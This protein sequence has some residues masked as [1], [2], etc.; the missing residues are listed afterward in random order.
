MDF[1]TDLKFCCKKII[2]K[3]IQDSNGPWKESTNSYGWVWDHFFKQEV[4]SI[5]GNF[6]TFIPIPLLVN[7]IP[8]FLCTRNSKKNINRI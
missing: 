4:N 5:K 2:Q 1:L 7:F 6:Y 3:S 8:I